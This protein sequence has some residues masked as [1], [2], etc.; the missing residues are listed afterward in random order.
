SADPGEFTPV[1]IGNETY[2]DGDEM[3]PVPIRVAR[4]LGAEIVIAVDVSAY[5][6]ETPAGVPRE[7]V[8][9]DERR[10][11]QIAAEAPAADIL[12]HPDIGYYAGYKEEY[13]RGVIAAAEAYTRAKMPE[14][15]AALEKRGQI[16]F[17]P[18]ASS[19]PRNEKG[20]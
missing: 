3:S 17:S 4:Q 18:A 10:A 11:R 9:K 7:W 14:I 6:S 12:R 8:E 15:R 13:R 16:P 5:L 1:P 19:V 2:V 20:I